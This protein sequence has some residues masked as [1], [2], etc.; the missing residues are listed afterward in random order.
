MP[1]AQLPQWLDTL[2]ARL[3][4]G[5]LV[6]F[7]DNNFVA[8]SSTPL[9]RHDAAGNSYQQRTLADGSAHEVLKNF[10]TPAQALAVLGPRAQQAQW[11]EFGHYWVLHYTV[12]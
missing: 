3:A 4:P 11:L 6:V 10:P 7:L 12:A 5:A 8:G 2:H 9:S 1:L